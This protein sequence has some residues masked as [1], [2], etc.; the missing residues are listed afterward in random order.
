MLIKT[1]MQLFS[2]VQKFLKICDFD[3]KTSTIGAG[4]AAASPSRFLG[5]KI[6]YN[7]ANLLR[8]GRNL[9]KIWVNLGE[10]WAKVIRF[11]QNQYLASPKSVDLLRLWSKLQKSFGS[12][13]STTGQE[14][15]IPTIFFVLV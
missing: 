15:S 5:G 9:S 3:I 1:Y 2:K 13:N 8:F 4:D 6:H 14:F 11:G 12:N 10:I 7:W